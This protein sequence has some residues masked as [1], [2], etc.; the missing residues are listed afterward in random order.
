MD[1]FTGRGPLAFLV[2]LV[3]LASPIPTATTS[4]TETVRYLL[5]TGVQMGDDHHETPV[6]VDTCVALCPFTGEPLIIGNPLFV[7]GT[8]IRQ[9]LVRFTDDSYGGD[10]ATGVCL[11]AVADG[12]CLPAD[13]F[14]GPLCG[15][16]ILFVNPPPSEMLVFGYSIVIGD[17]NAACGATKGY[18]TVSYS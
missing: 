8:P 4:G 14:I 11:S 13:T 6:G 15:G 7:L 16:Y 17:D 12:L 18:A 10:V 2:V 1:R 3:A 5:P 9:L